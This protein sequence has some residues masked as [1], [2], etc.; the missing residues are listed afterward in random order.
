MKDT[1]RMYRE[2][3]SSFLDRS[4]LRSVK[5]R[6]KEMEEQLPELKLRE[7]S[8]RIIQSV[9]YYP[10]PALEPGAAMAPDQAKKLG[11][12]RD[13]GIREDWPGGAAGPE[14]MEAAGADIETAGIRPGGMVTRFDSKEILSIARDYFL[15]LREEPET[16]WLQHLYAW[17]LHQ[18]FPQMPEPDGAHQFQQGRLVL[19]RLLRAVYSYERK[20]F[21]FDPTR[22]MLLMSDAEVEAGGFVHEY[23]R[24]HKLIRSRYVYEFMRV[25][26]DI[27]PYNTLGHI[28]GVHYIAMHMARQLKKAGVPV[29]LALI[30]GA[31]AAHDMGKYGCRKQ[32]ENRIPYLHYFYTNMVLE[33]FH[34]PKIAHIAANHSTWDLEL[35]N[36]SVESLLLIYSDFRVKSTRDSQRREIIHFYSL[37]DAY[38]VILNK[39]DNVDEA[40]ARRYQKVYSKLEDFENYMIEHGAT[41][42]LPADLSSLLPPEQEEVKE[43]VLKEGKVYIEG[44]GSRTASYSLG[45]ELPLMHGED[46]IGQLK[47]EAVDHNIRVMSRFNSE[48]EFGSLLEDAR[49]ERNWQNLRTYMDILG[50]YSTYMSEKQKTMT[51]QF[52]YEVLSNR[53]SDIRDQAA[54]LMG[55][56]VARFGEEYKKELPKDVPRPDTVESNIFQFRRILRMILKPDYKFTDQHIRWISSTA[57]PFINSVLKNCNPDRRSS[58]IDVLK[59]CFAAPA[60]HEDDKLDENRILILLAA[61]DAMDPKFMTESFMATVR[62]FVK[63]VYR[64]Y[65]ESVDLM[66]IDLIGRM[67]GAGTLLGFSPDQVN[68]EFLTLLG[69]APAMNE[70]ALSEQLSSIYLANLKT[71]TSWVVKAANIRF[72]RT[73]PK[74]II[75]NHRM[76]LATHFDNLVKVSETVIVRKTAGE[77]LIAL[78]SHMPYEQRNELVV[79]LLNGLD[80]GDYQF[81]KYIPDYLGVAMLQLPPK[82]LD[83]IIDELEKRLTGSSDQ[84]AS[85]CMHTIG[86]LLEH[87]DSYPTRFEEAEGAHDRRRLRLLFLLLK[88]F[89]SYRSVISREAMYSLGNYVFGS[90]RLTLEKKET[91]FRHCGKKLMLLVAENIESELEFYNSAAALNQLY[92]FMGE[93]ESEVGPFP[94]SEKPKAAFFPGTFD[95]FSYGH[96]QIAKTIR[97]MGF[98]VYLALDE[99]S[100]SKNTQ[101]RMF[102]R[103]IMTMSVANEEDIYIWP[104]N[105][106]INIANEIDIAE[107][108]RLFQ[109]RAVYLAVGSDVVRNASSYRM[110]PGENTV[111]SLNHII[112]ARESAGDPND[113]AVEKKRRGSKAALAKA[114]SLIQGHVISLTLP[115]YYEDISSTRIRENIDLDR[116][117][118]MLLDPMVQNYIYENSLYLR[119]PTYKHVL[120]AEALHISS[121]DFH[122]EEDILS[123]VWGEM[124]E[125]G[126]NPDQ[127]EKYLRRKDVRT[128][129]IETQGRKNSR[130]AGFAASHRVWSEDLLEEFG[131]IETAGHIR[132]HSTGEVA[133]IGAF[134]TSRE[135]DVNAA[136][137]AQ[138]MLTEIL[139]GLIALDYTYAVYH[140]KDPAGLN[141]AILDAFRRQ[142][143]VNISLNGQEPIY[144]CDMRKP[145][146]LFRDVE[147]VIKSPFNKNPRVLRALDNA[148]SRLLRTFSDI[149]PGRLILS[150]QT[151]VVHSKIME[152]VAEE[153]GV[154]TVPGGVKD[155]GPYMSVPFGKALSGVIVPNTVTKALHTEKYFNPELS[156]FVVREAKHY[157]TLTNQVRTIRSFGREVILIDD[158]LHKGYRMNNIRPMFEEAGITVRKAIFGVMTGRARDRMKVLGQPADAAYFLPQISIWLNERDCY[159]FIGGDSIEKSGGASI[160]FILPY[161]SYSFVGLTDPDATFKY[162]EACL[163]N[164][165]EILR[166]L[167]REYQALFSKKLTL[168]RLGEVITAPRRPAIRQGLEYDGSLAPSFYVEDDIRAAN[169]LHMMKV[170]P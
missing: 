98:E 105:I 43:R 128:V 22:D 15:P 166:A 77:A 27:T 99:F 116:D 65:S 67:P 7:L 81:S 53:E 32:E 101:P 82:E 149:F 109:G 20:V 148:H 124:E 137:L 119:E 78:I 152:L 29:D 50:E 120:Q 2:I 71:N 143:F 46:V 66:V 19:L 73:L 138:M 36:L 76:Q 60:G 111:Q 165:A 6:K 28:S 37:Q 146:V 140:P 5:L 164:A 84:T 133:V 145:I 49:S 23:L 4:F 160:N 13:P 51:L 103:K 75:D 9:R 129:Y 94:I 112:F 141:P 10:A 123:V 34:L 12:R 93:Y 95:P 121:L 56:I 74:E 41:P 87:I 3:R 151:S 45:S 153:N 96:K 18:L 125:K 110:E 44:Q 169:R 48:T 63:K 62:I 85:S 117:I 55:Q 127:M 26:I 80:I 162:S 113:P 134:Y 157:G 102:R 156:H 1:E 104:E 59:S 130:I 115:K 42:K 142:G 170:R 30:S 21:P 168:S 154:S 118:S 40:K 11:F 31:A 35:E 136:D 144:A 90:R 147:T 139:S 38:D 167:E 16:G 91:L 159:P 72:L 8:A 83:E 114:K 79:E 126:Y 100:W 150:Y 88:G 158:L 68:Q 57:T 61:V 92:R 89:S 161:T 14:E 33:R 106:P 39:L 54:S 135:R 69:I 64:R 25:G 70:E 155:R 47:F 17:L 107:L 122:N 86:V 131:S 58:Y 108:K 24:M 97:D 52:L 132:E 163:T